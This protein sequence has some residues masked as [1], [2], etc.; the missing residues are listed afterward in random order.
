MRRTVQPFVSMTAGAAPTWF[1][2]RTRVAISIDNT[3]SVHTMNHPI[4]EYSLALALPL[5]I[6]FGIYLFFGRTPDRAAFGNYLRSRRIMGA[7]LLL[8]A[9]NYSVHLF[10]EI[11]FVDADAAILMNLST[12]F[13]CYWL[14]SSALTTLLDRAYLTRRRWTVHLGSWILFTAMDTFWPP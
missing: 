1:P 3:Y 14:F 5:M 10:C 11:R 13:L 9:L 4:Y 8:L 6:F 2:K 12:Y 7:A